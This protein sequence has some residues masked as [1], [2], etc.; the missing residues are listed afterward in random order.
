[1]GTTPILVD[2]GAKINLIHRDFLPT[3]WR[4][5]IQPYHFNGVKTANKTGLKVVGTI[6]LWLQL[7]ELRVNV[8]FGV[9][10]AV[11][12]RVILGTPF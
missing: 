4:K 3:T 8:W 12:Q 10:E 11:A 6:G 7:G 1:M 5:T 2:T 9:C